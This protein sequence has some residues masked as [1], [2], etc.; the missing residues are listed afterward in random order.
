MRAFPPIT[1]TN[2]NR[3]LHQKTFRLAKDLLSLATNPIPIK[4][5]LAMTG[6]MTEEFRLPLCPMDAAAKE[7]LRAA[8][9]DYGVL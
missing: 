6:R 9:T 3:R 5:A 7:H 8:L 4:T 1:R 2:L